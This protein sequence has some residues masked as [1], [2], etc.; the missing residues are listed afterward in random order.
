MNKKTTM[1]LSVAFGVL[2]AFGPLIGTV[3]GVF[4]PPNVIPSSEIF[5]WDD[6]E[7][8]SG[9]KWTYYYNNGNIFGTLSRAP[10]FIS[11]QQTW[12]I[13]D[14]SVFS[15]SSLQ[16]G[17]AYAQSTMFTVTGDYVATFYFT[18]NLPRWTFG[19]F[20]D[21]YINLRMN[22]FMLESFNGMTYVPITQLQPGVENLIELRAVPSSQVFSVFIEKQFLGTYQFASPSHAGRIKIGDDS[23]AP[24]TGGAAFWNVFVVS[25]LH[26]WDHEIDFES[27]SIASFTKVTW[28]QGLFDVEPSTHSPYVLHMSNTVFGAPEPYP[29]VAYGFS[30]YLDIPIGVDYTISL[31][32]MIPHTDNV[33]VTVISDGSAALYVTGSDLY[34][35]TGATTNYVTALTPGVWYDGIT[36]HIHPLAGVYEVRILGVVYGPF[37]F[38]SDPA[39]QR[40]PSQFFMGSMYDWNHL[41]MSVGEAYWDNIRVEM[42]PTLA[43]CGSLWPGNCG[44]DSINPGK[45]DVQTT[46]TYCVIY[47][48]PN[49]DPPY[50]NTPVV[51]ILNFGSEIHAYPMDPD[52]GGGWLGPNDDYVTGRRYVKSTTLGAGTHYSYYFTAKDITGLDAIPTP[53]YD[54]PDVV[55]NSWEYLEVSGS[56][57]LEP[58]ENH[59]MAYDSQTGIIVMFGGYG[60]GYLGDTWELVLGSSPTWEETSPGTSPQPRQRH[61][62]AG[63]GNGW[64]LLFGG[65]NNPDYFPETWVYDISANQWYESQPN[66]SPPA[67]D[68]A[69]M[70]TDPSSG[71]VL[72]FG[73]FNLGGRL[74]DTWVY[75]R[76]SL[77]DNGYWEQLNPTPSPGSRSRHGIVYDVASGAFLQ[78]GG[79]GQGGS[80]PKDTWTFDWAGGWEEKDIAPNCVPSQAEGYGIA[81]DIGNEVTVLY[82]GWGG[83]PP[84]AETYVYDKNDGYWTLMEQLSP[85]GKRAGHAMVYSSQDQLVVMFGG[86]K[87]TGS[88]S[89]F[90][91]DVWVYDYA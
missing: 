18:I 91:N 67:R 90:M 72:L 46:F 26:S 6:V 27:G 76:G 65:F 34:A 40:P 54:G 44:E 86:Q 58:R 31:D 70:A 66:P 3:R 59:A 50:P 19:V 68:G 23:S 48:D 12:F 8:A 43:P 60:M 14:S 35:Y 39:Y 53:E 63:L 49:N 10:T 56:E 64:V 47:R 73:G 80:E 74:G 61:A 41:G 32:F 79:W 45:G 75:H 51:H 57:F 71:D 15:M 30:E 82:G 37:P 2:L 87:F 9:A 29:G 33:N 38:V 25:A 24:N 17:Y 62:M 13:R 42:R 52:S 5:F 88:G 11:E 1:T 16:T 4:P 83:L 28:Q 22:G 36:I 89:A 85:Q 69:F 78:Y 81:Y 21:G 84:H 55:L 20:D 7:G 77:P